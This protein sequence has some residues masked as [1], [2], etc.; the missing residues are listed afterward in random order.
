MSERIWI[1]QIT[2]PNYDIENPYQPFGMASPYIRREFVLSDVD[3]GATLTIATLGI[4][5]VYINGRLLTDH[6]MAPEVD[7]NRK[8]V[9]SHSYPIA[10]YLRP[11]KNVI[12]IVL[13]DGWYAS[14][15]S[16]ECRN[17]FGHYPLK[18]WY[19]IQN[20][21]ETIE[22][23]GSET[24]ATGEVVYADNQ[25]GEK[26]DHRLDVG[27]FSNPDFDASSFQKVST[28]HV[29]IEVTPSDLP[30]VKEIR[31]TKGKT[32]FSSRSC[33]R[34]DFG[35]NCAAVLHVVAKG[36]RGTVLRARHSERLK[37][38]GELYTENLRKAKAEDYFILRGEGE[39]T[40]LPRFTFH[41]FRYAEIEIQGDA[42][43]L[44]V[45]QVAISSPLKETGEFHPENPLIAQLDQ[46]IT[47]GQRSNFLA[48]PTDCP[49]RDERLG[50]T[51]DAQIF[52]S[53]AA[54]RQDVNAFFRH[55]LQRSVTPR[56]SL[57]MASRCSCLMSCKKCS[58][59]ATP[60]GAMRSATSLISIISSMEKKTSCRPI[61]HTWS[62]SYLSWKNSAAPKKV[63]GQGQPSGTG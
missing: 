3:E 39:E 36:S 22:S 17:I 4:S 45:E 30:P 50:W 31:R 24:W 5:L 56:N 37:D 10:P 58:L 25:N 1:G 32:I 49:Q 12:G 2:D 21:S 44:S 11:G 26:I 53:A 60:V 8:R 57:A 27:D 15:L 41:G 55:Y 16:V 13:G 14:F 34:F 20:G 38:N 9:S 47:W 23:D 35:Q 18:A 28:Y 40:F 33:V 52:F 48:L 43:L 62:V 59:G 42:T 7:E 6:F 63:Y 54:Y 29:S 51:G 46:N 19:R 61:T